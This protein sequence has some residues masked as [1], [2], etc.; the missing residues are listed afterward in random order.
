MTRRASG[1][2]QRRWVGDND[3]TGEIQRWV[4]WGDG[5]PPEDLSG[6]ETG[7]DIARHV[8]QAHD[9]DWAVRTGGWVLTITADDS[10]VDELLVS[11]PHILGAAPYL[12]AG[13]TEEVP[14]KPMR[15]TLR[16][17]VGPRRKADQPRPV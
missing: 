15:G 12:A 2:E 5:E 1:T 17:D 3:R 4:L 14:D 16:S 11:Q 10:A 7:T 6:A 8:A 13:K 9:P